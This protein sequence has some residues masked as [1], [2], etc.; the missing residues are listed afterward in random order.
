MTPQ[1]RFLK[2][3]EY[4]ELMRITPTTV[5]TLIKERQLDALKVGGQYRI[6]NP[7]TSSS[8]DG[9]LHSDHAY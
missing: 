6:P 2:V 8:A 9:D 7:M 3:T 5:R 4:A 1:T